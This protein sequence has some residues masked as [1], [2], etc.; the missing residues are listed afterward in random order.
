MHHLEDPEESLKIINR[1]LSEKGFLI[2]EFANKLHWKAMFKN[3]MCGNLTF[4]LEIFPTDIRSDKN[5]KKH[6]LPFK[7]YHP[8]LIKELLKTAKFEIVEMR[9]V[10][11]VRSPIIK[12]YLPL[13][14]LMPIEKFFQKSLSFL[15]F[16]PSVFILAQKKGEIEN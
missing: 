7:N 12:K 11:N 5:V 14:A 9:S 15:Q 4:P 2:I 8:D 3:L 10:S 13:E 16:G 6:T 1:L